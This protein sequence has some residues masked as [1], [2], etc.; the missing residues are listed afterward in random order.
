MRK[1]AR[2]SAAP[3]YRCHWP[4][5][6]LTVD[7]NGDVVDCQRWDAPIANVR[8]QPLREIARCARVEEL[9]GS[10]GERCNACASPARVEPSGL[11]GMKPQMLADSV[12]SLTRGPSAAPARAGS[13]YAR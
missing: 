1:I 2:H 5:M 10:V 7:A 6:C 8:D 11:W 13:P 4:K 9:W 12:R 3:S